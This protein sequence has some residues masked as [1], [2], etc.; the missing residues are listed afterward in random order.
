MATKKKNVSIPEEVIAL[1]DKLIAAVPDA[2]RK[3]AT[4]PYTSVNGNMFSFLTAEGKL[5]LRLSEEDRNELIT[6]HNTGLVEAHG[7]VLKEY[8]AVPDG[9]FADAA[10][11]KKYFQMSYEYT[12]SLK[13][14]KTTASK[15]Q[16]NLKK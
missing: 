4:M 8:V 14:K 6:K 16:K 3:G 12:S 9:L 1:Y 15:P 7:T 13:P 11:M 10:Q 2:E 5:A